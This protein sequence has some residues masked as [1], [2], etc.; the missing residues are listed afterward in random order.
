M[1]SK[2]RLRRNACTG[3]QRHATQEQAVA[4]AIHHRKHLGGSWLSAYR[5]RFCNGWHVGH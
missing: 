3:K 1:A 2:R 4:H 5:C